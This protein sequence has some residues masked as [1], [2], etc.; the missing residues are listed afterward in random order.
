MIIRPGNRRTIF[1]PTMV[2]LDDMDKFERQKIMK[3]R[4]F[5]LGV[6]V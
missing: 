4:P 1:K 2:S 6:I 3:K 5:A